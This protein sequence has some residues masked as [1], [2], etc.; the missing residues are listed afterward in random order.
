MTINSFNI[1]SYSTVC[2]IHFLFSTF[3][4]IPCLVIPHLKGMY[5]V[6]SNNKNGG[7]IQKMI[8]KTTTSGNPNIKMTSMR[9]FKDV[10]IK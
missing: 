1:M 9:A 8:T 4:S 6:I 3:C 7:M 5:H 10:H 2:L